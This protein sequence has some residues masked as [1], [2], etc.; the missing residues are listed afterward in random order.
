MQLVAFTFTAGWG[1]LSTLVGV[2]GGSLGGV[3]LT[4]R[5]NRASERERAASGASERAADRV[6]E[7]ELRELEIRA[8]HRARLY[9]DRRTAYIAFQTA[10]RALRRLELEGNLWFNHLMLIASEQ[11]GDTDK[12]DAAQRE[13]ERLRQEAEIA[14]RDAEGALIELVVVASQPV[15]RA[16]ED[17]LPLLQTMGIADRKIGEFTGGSDQDEAL[18]KAISEADKALSEVKDGEERLREAIRTELELDL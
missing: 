13:R 12:L 14:Q 16:A 15:Q 5:S 9:A 6:H 2:L 10:F 18:T 17:L 11:P 8:A 7:R 1:A 4:Q 3:V